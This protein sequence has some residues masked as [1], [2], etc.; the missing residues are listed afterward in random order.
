M[1]PPSPPVGRLS[2]APLASSSRETLPSRYPS[3]IVLGLKA[4]W[5]PSKPIDGGPPSQAIGPAWQPTGDF[6]EREGVLERSDWPIASALVGGA[7]GKAKPT[8]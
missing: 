6:W 5:P 2:R 7:G 8:G 1:E 4:H 3:G